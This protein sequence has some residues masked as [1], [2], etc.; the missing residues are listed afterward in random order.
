MAS[1][2]NTYDDP[3]LGKNVLTGTQYSTTQKTI[4]QNR[5]E[6]YGID[7]TKGLSDDVAYIPVQST[8]DEG[9]NETTTTEPKTIS[10]D[11]IVEQSKKYTQGQNIIGIAP[12]DNYYNFNMFTEKDGIDV[13]LDLSNAGIIYMSFSNGNEEVKIS[14]YTLAGNYA[15]ISQG[16]VIFKITKEEAKKILGFTN[17]NFYITSKKQTSSSSSD[18]TVIYLG[19]YYQYDQLFENSLQAEFD[20][21]K[22]TA[23]QQILKLQS[24]LT[25]L[26]K[27]YTTLQSNYNEL[28]TTSERL[29]KQINLYTSIIDKYKKYL[30]S[31]Q[32]TI[33][34]KELGISTGADT[35]P[36]RVPKPPVTMGSV[37]ANT[38]P[39]VGGDGGNPNTDPK[40]L[41][42]KRNISNTKYNTTVN[43][44]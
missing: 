20:A 40:L 23:Q 11:K 2:I 16:Q 12:F 22:V 8:T 32:L 31:E 5:I 25:Q 17:N 6:N 38:D 9:K 7:P 33:L 18:E 35:T 19:K 21:Y 30:S 15:D 27:D 28:Y 44:Q 4:N 37:S 39:P 36:A 3:S 42:Y 43:E 10:I 41:G 24:A 14:N 26:D 13:P 1:N 29:Q 34:N